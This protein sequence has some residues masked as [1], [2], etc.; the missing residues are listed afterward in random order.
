MSGERVET[1]LLDD[2]EELELLDDELELE[3]L[4]EL[5][6]LLLELLDDEEELWLDEELEEEVEEE[7]EELVSSTSSRR[8]PPASTSAPPFGWLTSGSEKVPPSALPLPLGP[9]NAA[10]FPTRF[11]SPAS[12]KSFPPTADGLSP[13]ITPE[14]CPD[15]PPSDPP[16]GS[17]SGSCIAP[18]VPAISQQAC[19]KDTAHTHQRQIPGKSSEHDSS[20]ERVCPVKRTRMKR[21]APAK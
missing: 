15:A 17:V 13:N 2:D 1:G 9:E 11:E 7:E 16:V 21:N 12:P 18:V 10:L 20:S 8:P 6:L 4:L 14:T 3:L 19:A 5:L